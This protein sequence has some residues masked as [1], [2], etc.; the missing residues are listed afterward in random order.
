MQEM[1][2]ITLLREYTEHDSEEA[3]ATL[4]TGHVNKVYSVAL[5]HTRN[6]H[7]AEEITQAV[8][9]ILAQKARHLGKRVVLSGWLYQTAQL[10][11]VTFIRSEIRRVC[12]EKEA[13]MQGLLN[14]TESDVWPQIAPLLDAAMAG[15]SETDRHAVVLRFFDGKSM[16]EIGAALGASED[17]VKM[18]VNRAV[19]KLRLFFKKRGV[20]VPAAVLTAAI[21]ANSVQAA[22][23]VLAKTA[24]AGALA[25]GATAPISTLTLIKGALKVM[26]W[27]KAKTAIV[28]GAAVILAV[29]TTGFV[30]VIAEKINAI[31]SRS[32]PSG[33]VSKQADKLTADRTTPKGT[34]LV[35]I[36]ALEKGDANA[37]IESFVFKTD[38]EVKLKPA[39]EA[40]VAASAR[41][42]RA[43][44][45]K[46]GAEAA[47]SELPNM[48][49]MLPADIIDSAQ[50]NIQGDSATVSISAGGKSGRPIQ[51]TKVNGEWK[52]AADG[53]VHLSPAVMNDIYGRIIQALNQT[54]PEIP[55]GKFQTAME[56][57]DKMKERAR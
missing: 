50:Q 5:R 31:A 3:F 10:T 36:N 28:I 52:M 56:A 18:R 14:E 40:L 37:Y 16:R 20:V 17:A 47:R 7:Q 51:F 29:G 42:N 30:I 13:H 24:T 4:V 53:F 27:T 12:R 1:D 33:F 8:F 44:S 45:D 43:M 57:V 11:A 25:K 41:F 34:M 54:T 19:E 55:Q 21:S 49:L 48:P 9:V 6:P 39:L 23:M 46:F 2:D 38:E 35:M 32:N 26:A 22:P 15:L